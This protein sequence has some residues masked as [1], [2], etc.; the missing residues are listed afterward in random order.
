MSGTLT[1]IHDPTDPRM[2]GYTSIRERDLR[3]RDGLFIAEGTVVVDALLRAERFEAVSLLVLRNRVAGIASVLANVPEGTPVYVAERETM[4]AIAGF[5]MHRGVLA[6]ARSRAM[7]SARDIA[8]G[9]GDRLLVGVGIANHDNSGGL[10]RVASAFGAAGALFDETC[11][12]AL[13]RKSIRVS[14]GAALTLPHAREGNAD[15]LI[16]LLREH[17][18]SPVALSPRAEIEIGA[19]ERGNRIALVVG[20]EGPGLPKSLLARLPTASIP[21][22]VGHDSLNVAVSAAVALYAL[23]L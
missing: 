15:E 22:A 7:P 6:L 9:M 13:Y 21:M 4:D 1:P 2:A 14:A 16:D 20:P 3:R 23:R 11:V 18:W 5:P 10:L 12:D 19:I 17:D 8:S